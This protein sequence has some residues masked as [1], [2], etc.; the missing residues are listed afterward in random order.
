MPCTCS[1]R[2]CENA[3]YREVPQAWG[4]D[5]SHINDT[6][7]CKANQLAARLKVGGDQ[8]QDTRAGPYQARLRLAEFG[9]WARAS[10]HLGRRDLHAKDALVGAPPV[11]RTAHDAR[12]CAQANK[13]ANHANRK[14]QVESEAV[15]ETERRACNPR[16]VKG[17]QA[18]KLNMW[19]MC[20]C[21]CMCECV[22]VCMCVCICSCCV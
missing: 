6:L 12:Q 20:I 22:C 8:L 16:R 4:V 11:V 17:V 10:L 9:A 13:E 21:V 15:G 2:T 5:R 19:C 14:Q 7:H 18:V 1:T 3:P